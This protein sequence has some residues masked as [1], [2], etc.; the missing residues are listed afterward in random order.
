MKLILQYNLLLFF[1]IL[2]ILGC[3]VQNKKDQSLKTNDQARTGDK[4]IPSLISNLKIINQKLHSLSEKKSVYKIG[5][6]EGKK[7]DKEY[8]LLDEQAYEILNGLFNIGSPVIPYAKEM[9]KDSDSN[10]RFLAVLI[11]GEVSKNREEKE[12]KEVITELLKILPSEE[13][14][15]AIN[16]MGALFKIGK[17]AIPYII[18]QL[19]NQDFYKRSYAFELLQIMTAEKFDCY[20]PEDTNVQDRQKAIEMI[21]EWWEKNKAEWKIPQYKNN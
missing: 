8:E 21:R 14:E 9:L 12:V 5:D 7:L 13:R 4:D 10:S 16:V 2:L 11:L 19:G 20:K 6:P 15:F 17:P 3:S 1:S 18:N